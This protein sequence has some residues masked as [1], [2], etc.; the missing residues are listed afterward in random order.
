[1]SVTL[2]KFPFPYRA[3]LAIS[4]DVD[5]S[6]SLKGYL[7]MVDYLNATGNTP[8]GPGL[9][10]EVGNSFWF[11]NGTQS[12]QLAYY[13]NDGT[14]ESPF[15]PHCRQFWA[16]GHIDSLHTYGDFDEGGYE[17]R[18]A[19]VAVQELSRNGASLPVWINHGT[20]MNH[21]NIG[22]YPHF[23][24]DL[25]GQPSYHLDLARA[26]GSRYFWIGR[27]THVLGQDARQ[28]LS[29]RTKNGL[30]RLLS[31][32]RY[33]NMRESPL[34]D[35]ENRLLLPI[36]FR[37]GAMGWDFQRWVN[38]RGE[39][40]T[41]DS[42]DLAVQ[43]RPTNLRR[44]IRNEGFLIIYTHFCEN[45]DPEAGPTQPLRASLA[46]LRQLHDEDRLLV[47]T[48]GRLLRYREVGLHLK[49]AA[50]MRDGQ[51]VININ[52]QLDTPVGM[53]PLTAADLQGLT[54]YSADPERVSVQLDSLPLP[55]QVNSKDHTGQQ[56]VSVPWRPLEYPRG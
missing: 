20:R 31:I 22:P 48:T 32:T 1:M 23:W 3:A 36:E 11:F 40:Q 35:L 54:F 45:L 21:Q 47:T 55:T 37:D 52:D 28:T 26:A 7:A 29:V 19:E 50:A 14:T 24:G 41:L 5:N 12:P 18:H 33:R 6:P 17:R 51:L 25:P 38:V 53:T 27:L 42:G 2:R 8:F 30:Q 46:Y 34:F 16:S 9:G 43:L 56:S 49:F 39:V 13:T 44:L 10:L 4:S 15:A